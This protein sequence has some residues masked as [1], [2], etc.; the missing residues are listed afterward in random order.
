VAERERA[1]LAAQSEGSSAK[2][3][4]LQRQLSTSQHDLDALRKSSGNEIAQL[5]DTLE[6]QKQELEILSRANE[7]ITR[8]SSAEKA[9]L[10]QEAERLVQKMQE[11][12]S[13]SRA[14]EALAHDS[15]AETAELKSICDQQTKDLEVLRRNIEEQQRYAQ[16]KL[17]LIEQLTAKRQEDTEAAVAN[18]LHE[19]QQ[20]AAAMEQVED[21][22]RQMQQ[23]ANE[24]DLVQQRLA[25]CSMEIE[26]LRKG[27]AKAQEVTARLQSQDKDKERQELEAVRTSLAKLQRDSM[28]ERSRSETLDG[29]LR[30]TTMQLETARQ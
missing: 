15:R 6:K 22:R 12:E 13:A 20:T 18:L 24:R 27:I 25:A 29:Q 17:E 7:A 30:N 14:N 26:Q 11:L 21:C 3:A 19:R 2:V 8:D 28:I 10:A 23:V 5:L 1:R 16:T 4:E 9:E